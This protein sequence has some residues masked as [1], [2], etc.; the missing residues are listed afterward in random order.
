[1]TTIVK[2]FLKMRFWRTCLLWK[3]ILKSRTEAQFFT[4]KL[5]PSE[6]LKVLKSVLKCKRS[7]GRETKIVGR[8]HFSPVALSDYIR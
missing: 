5:E 1:M 6:G 8:E 2:M 4:I 3:V 7:H